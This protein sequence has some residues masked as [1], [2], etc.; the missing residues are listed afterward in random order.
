MNKLHALL[1]GIDC[2]MPRTINRLPNYGHLYG[3]V[4]DIALIESFLTT[5]LPELDVRV[6]SLTASG[7]GK[8][9][10]EA[11]ERWPTKANI[12]AAFQQLAADVQPGEQ[13]Y[14]HYA[15]HGGQALT[16][17]PQ[18]KGENGL[19]ESLVPTDYGQI[20]TMDEPEDR[21]LRDLEL[22]A[23]LQ[24][25]VDREAVV[26]VVL[27]SCHSG[28]AS[29]GVRPGGTATPRGSGEIDTLPRTP[30]A[31]VAPPEALI[32]NWE[33]QSRGTR[34]VQVA[35][36]WLPDPQ[37]YTLLSA[38]R[39]LELASE[40]AMPN[41]QRHGF[42]TYWLWDALQR[43]M[44]SWEMIHQQVAAKLRVVNPAQSP[45]LQGVGDRTI[46]GGA[47]VALPAGVNVLDVDG[48]RVRL[49]VG[50][51][52][53]AQPGAQFFVY[54][55]GVADFK[56]TGQ[57]LA[58]VEIVESGDA[59]AWARIVRRL[60][61]APVERGCQ[62]LLFNP[63]AAQ[64]WPVYFVRGGDAP[65]ADEERAFAALAA[66]LGESENR[67][68]RPAA[69]GE[70]EG[71]GVAVTG[72]GRFEIRDI[73]GQPFPHLYPVA[74]NEIP[75]LL[76]QLNHL[77]RYY[78]VLDLDNPDPASP[79]AGSLE[80][81]LME[82]LDTPFAEPG[83]IPA[84]KSG[85]QIYYLRIRN[86]FP[87]VD[88]P[89]DD[90]PAYIEETRRRTLNVT[91]LSLDPEWRVSRVIPPQGDARDQIELGPG[92]TLLLPRYDLPGQPQE[93][94]AF[95]SSL[96]EGSSAAED[97]FKVFATTDTTSSYNSLE[98]PP[99]QRTRDRASLI[100]APKKQQPEQSWTTA[101]VSVGVVA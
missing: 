51:A 2:Y 77:A 81:T 7:S 55:A 21:Y 70:E 33:R 101:L 37:G 45:Q 66:A 25:L 95:L 87:P 100:G 34:S 92:E 85:E 64:Q 4:G 56:D 48:E 24:G 31:S 1:I 41:G 42:L 54:P 82:S 14:I 3:C 63:G 65:A 97:I 59:D 35:A 60:G 90:S 68:V 96:P 50:R 28:G 62:A 88:G 72:D 83:G 86:L 46:F 5:R 11:A 57:R 93:L 39:A 98:L 94:P 9:P 79:V 27:D 71:F 12:V 38:C 73:S 49:G 23:L 16:L 84:V 47:A 30:A 10:T 80:V 91:V 53:G 29:R 15:G 58:V 20:E 13:V 22:A 32:A 40:D 8:K 6:N 17:F 76:Y 36:G 89:P 74:V 26:T 44:H 61:D 43:P 75:E 18:V 69:A 99:L 52:G 67:F 78:N 19:D